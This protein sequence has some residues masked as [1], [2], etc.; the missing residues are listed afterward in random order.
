ML[1]RKNKR[2]SYYA[3]YKPVVR[4]FGMFGK[5]R[6]LQ[7]TKKG[8]AFLIADHCRRCA[9]CVVRSRCD[10]LAALRQDAARAPGPE[11]TGSP[12]DDRL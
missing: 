8:F 12:L 7:I 3:P 10:E 2:R 5:S 6:T 4:A 9:A 1:R 11:P